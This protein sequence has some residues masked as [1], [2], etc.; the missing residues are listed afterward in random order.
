MSNQSGFTEALGHREQMR[1]AIDH[2]LKEALPSLLAIYAFGSQVEGNAGLD[3]DLDLAVLLPGYA[4]P[5]RLWELSGDLADLAGCPVD[6]LDF[7]AASTV[8]QYRIL[9]T[10]ERWWSKNTAVDCYEAAI[11]SDKTELDTARAALLA[12]IQKEG[13]IHAR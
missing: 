4:S 2:K 6:L 3:S 5:E 9:T 13:C 11:L 10:G 12:D 7:R 8:M 1:Q